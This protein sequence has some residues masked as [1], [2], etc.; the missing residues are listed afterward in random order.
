MKNINEMKALSKKIRIHVLKMMTYAQSSHIGSAYSIVEILVVLYLN[1]LNINPENPKKHDRDKFILSKAHGSTALYALLAEMN[2]FPLE[3]LQK[4]Y[5]DDGLLPGHLDKELVPGV[6]FSLGSLGHGL[7]VGVGMAISNRQTGN[8]GRIFVLLSDGECNEGSVWEAIML[9]SH[10][11]LKNLIAIIDYNKIQSFGRTNEV[12]NQEPL[13]DRWRVFGWEVIEVDGHDHQELLKVFKTT[14]NGPKVIIAHTIK[15]K[16]V[17]FMEDTLDWH[18]K[19]PNKEQY[20]IALKE[21]EK[22]D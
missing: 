19:S 5:I 12:I 16:G 8:A 2:F 14:Q 11:K 1:V 9:A 20:D 3:Y 17:S 15:G 4:Y 6:E 21:L 13:V 10:L 7:S 18:Y 22:A